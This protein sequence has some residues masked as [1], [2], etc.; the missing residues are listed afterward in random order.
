MVNFLV[1][2]NKIHPYEQMLLVQESDIVVRNDGSHVKNELDVLS[3]FA[4][5]ELP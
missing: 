4:T 3:M 2:C 1:A 5:Y